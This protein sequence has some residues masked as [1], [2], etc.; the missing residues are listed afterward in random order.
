M[1]IEV[2]PSLKD[3]IEWLSERAKRSMAH[4]L[5]IELLVLKKDKVSG[6]MPVNEKTRQ[7]FGLLHGGASVALAETLSSIGGWLN[8]DERLFAVVGAEINA[9]HL[10]PKKDGFLTGVAVPIQLGK[11]IQVW[12]IRIGDEAGKLVCISRCTLAVVAITLKG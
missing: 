1:M 3:K 7:P 9:N 10:R 2:D 12:E 8:V 5:E 6:R 4:A 11:T